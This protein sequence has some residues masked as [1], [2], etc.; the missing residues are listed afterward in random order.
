[1]PP[2]ARYLVFSFIILLLPAGDNIHY[3]YHLNKIL[4]NLNSYVNGY[5]VK[6]IK[7]IN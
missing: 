4:K 3:F 7:D 5:Y 2:A 6:H 1:M